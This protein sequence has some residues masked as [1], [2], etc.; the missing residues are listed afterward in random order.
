[1]CGRLRSSTTRSGS[2]SSDRADGRAAVARRP[3]DVAARRQRAL[4][5]AQDLR[6]VVD[7]QHD[8]AAHVA[9]GIRTPNVAPPPGVSVAQISPSIA[10]DE[11]L[12]DREPEP[13]AESRRSLRQPVER[14]EEQGLIAEVEPRT[15]VDHAKRPRSRPRARPG[16]RSAGRADPRTARAA[17]STRFVT[18][19][20]DEQRVAAS[21]ARRPRRCRCRCRRPGQRS[22]TP[23]DRGTDQVV[24]VHRLALGDERARL[25]PRH[26][27]EVR[28][29]LLE[30]A[31]RGARRPRAPR[32]RP[33]DRTGRGRARR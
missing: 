22:R 25:D 7:D 6:L 10:T 15:V 4:D 20:L 30:P 5:R 21:R 2:S 3:H 32:A 17:F 27:Q 31:R 12:A 8:R 9:A 33:P 11:P 14:R 19:A 23:S 1:M 29:Q 24:E 28:D 13:G 18:I 16:A 26:V